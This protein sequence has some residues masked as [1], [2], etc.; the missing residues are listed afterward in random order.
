MS[1]TTPER[2]PATSSGGELPAAPDHPLTMPDALVRAARRFPAYGV[3]VVGPDGGR[4]LLSYPRLL[5]QAEAVLGGLRARGVEAGRYAVLRLSDA[6][7]F[8]VFWGCVLG[9]AVPVTTGGP[10]DYHAGDPAVETIVHCWRSLDRPVVVGGAADLDGLRRLPLAGDV[11]AAADLTAGVPAP[12]EPPRLDLAGESVAMLQLSSG[13]TG[14]PKIVPLTHR[15]ISEYAAGARA[16]LDIRAGDVLL[17]WLPLDHIA[18]LLLYHIGGVFLGASS[19]HVDTSYVLA[20]PLRWLD[21]MQ[22]HG[23]TH[24][25]APN[26]GYQLVADAAAAAPGRSWDLRTVRRLVSGGEQCLPE[27]FRA[28]LGATAASG[29]TASM[30]TMGWGMSETATGIAFDSFGRTGSLHRVRPASLA[31]QVEWA[32]AGEECVELLSVGPP[33]PGAAFRIVD[34]DNRVLPEGWVGRL[35]VRSA[36][37]TPGYVGDPEATQAAYPEPGWLDT[38]DLAFMVDGRV[39]ITGRAKDIIVLNGQN[40]LSHEIER[41]ADRTEGTLPGLVAACGVPDPGSGTET[42]VVFYAPDPA[43]SVD[44]DQVGR[45]IAAAVG[46]RLRLAVAATVAVPAADFPRTSGGKIQRAVLRERFLAGAGATAALERATAASAGAGGAPAGG[47]GPTTPAAVRRAVLDAAAAVAGRPVDPAT[48]FYELG[49]GS[50]Q[51]VQLRARLATALGREVPQPALFAHPSVDALADH[52]AGALEQPS[53]PAA[54]PTAEGRVAVIGMAARLPGAATVE[55]LWANL[56]AGVTS[57]HR[58]TTAELAAAGVPGTDLADPDFVPVS[59]VLD[60]IA[61][62]DAAFF[63][64]SPKEA[65]LLDP[66]H[67]L[68]LEVCHHAL[69]DAGYAGPDRSLRIGLFAG[70]GMNLYTHHTYLRHNLAAAVGSA[71][72]AT[73]LGAALGNLPDFLATRVAYRLGLTGPAVGVQT[74]CST[75]LVAVHLAI[76][77]LLAGDADIA[78]VGAAAVH[79]PQVTGYRYADGSILSRSGRCR[80]FDAEADGTVG[81]NGVAAV[82]LKTLDRA[83]ADGDTIHAVILGSAVNNDG[84]TKVGFTAPGVAGQVD[85]VRAALRAAG[86]PAGSVGYVE[87]HGTGTALG[88]PVEYQALA[89]AYQGGTGFLGSVKANVGHLDSCAG[90][91]GLL[92]AVLAV[93]TGQVPPQPGFDRPHPAIDL[94]GGPFRITTELVGWPEHAVPRRAGVSALGVGGTNAHVVVEEPPVAPPIST[95]SGDGVPALLPL[96]AADPAALRELAAAYRDELAAR[97]GLRPADL[98]ATTALGRRH[99]RHRLVALGG[100]AAELAAAL[101]RFVA[102]EAAGSVLTGQ[103]PAEGAGP[104]AFAFPGQG[105]APQALLDLAGRFGVVRDVL[106]QAATAY[107]EAAGADLPDRLRQAV[108]GGLSTDLAQPALVALGLGLAALWRSWGVRP[109]YVLGHSVGEYAALAAAGAL[110]V[111]DAV[112]LAAHRGRLMHDLLGPGA[113]LAVQADRSTVDELMTTV[114][115]LAL[116]AVNGPAQHVVAGPAGA[117]EEAARHAD[118]AGVRVRRL[119]VDRAFHTAAVEP[120]LDRFRPVVDAVGFQ[121]LQLPFVS[122]VDGSVREPGWLPDA[123]YLCRQARQPVELAAAVRRL[124]ADGCRVAVEAGPDRVLAGMAAAVA[125]TV[126]WVPSQHRG[127]RPVAGVWRAVAAA[128]CAGVPLDWAA[129]VDGCG[130]RR[131]QLPRYPFQRRRYWVDGQPG[132]TEPAGMTEPVEVT[133]PADVARSADV[134]EAQPPGDANG[135]GVLERVRAMTASRLGVPAS[136]VGPEDSFLG[137]G[138]DSFLLVTM[139]REVER[140]LGA[141]IPVRDLFGEVSTPRRLAEAITA[142]AGSGAPGPPAATPIE[143]ASPAA[144]MPAAAMPEGAVHA[145][146]AGSPAAARTGVPAGREL[147]PAPL[148]VGEIIRQQLDLMGRQLELLARDGATS[149]VPAAAPAFVPAAASTVPEQPAA[150]VE[151]EPA[152]DAADFSLYFFGDYPGEAGDAYQMILDA[153]EFG[154]RHG[155]HALWVPERHFHSFGGIFPN[156]SVLA[157]ALAVRTRRIR[158]NAGSVVLPLHHPVRVAEEWSVVDNLSGGRVGLGCAPGWHSN[159]FV[160]FPEH[161]G[162]H[163]QVMYEHLDTVRRLWRGEAVPARSGTGEEIEVRLFPRP[164]Q[165]IPPVFTAVVGNPDSY[166]EAARRDI[167]VVTNLMTQDVAQLA[168]NIA[169]YRRTRAEHGLDP[170]GGRVVVLLHTYLGADLAQARERAFEPFCGYLRSSFSLLGQVANSLGIN[171]DLDTTPDDDVRFLLSRAYQRYCEQRAL[172]GTV[173]SSRD[174]VRAV[175]DA[176]VDEVACF[177]D[178]GL[179]ADAVRDGLPFIDALRR[180][181]PRRP[182]TA[183]V[184]G[185]QPS[186]KPQ[187]SRAAKPQPSRAAEPQPFRAA[188]P[189]PS[190]AAGQPPPEIAPLSPAQRRLWLVEQMDPGSPAYN[191]AAAIRLAGP[192]DT[193]AL[194]GALTDVV[195]RHAPLRTTYRTMDGE[196]VQVVHERVPVRCPVVDHTG[197]DEADAVRQALAEESRRV[198]DLAEGPVFALR[199]LRF[200]ATHHVLV[201]AFHHLATDGRSY[202]VLTQDVSACYRAR[203]AGGTPAL[204]PLPVT[205][206]QLARDQQPD[207]ARLEADLRYWRERLHPAPP[208]LALPSDL[209]RPTAPSAAGRS[210]FETVPAEVAA[211]VRRF[212]RATR[213]TPFT[214]LLSAFAVALGRAGGQDDLVIGTGA[215]IRE[216]RCEDL[217]GFFVDTV[218]LRLSLAGDPAFGELAA[219]VQQAAADGYAHS[220]VAFDAL[221]REVAP[222][223]ESGRNP[224]F[225]VAIEYENGGAFHF[226]LPGVVATPLPYGLDK[227][228]VDLMV[229]V[230][231]GEEIRCHIEFRTEVLDEASVRRLF[232][233][234]R[235]VLER[236]T[237]EPALRLSRLAA[238]LDHPGLGVCGPQVPD[239]GELLHDLFLRQANRTPDAVAVV[240]GETRWSYRELRERA[241]AVAGR[242]A[243]A[244]AGP[245]DVVAVLLPR[246]PE[247]V[248]AQLGVLMAGAAFLPL[249][250][251]YP[252]ARL[253]GLVADSGARLVVTTAE[254]SRPASAVPDI[255]AVPDGV[256]RLL[257]EEAVAAGLPAPYARPGPGQAAWCVYT[258]GSTGA[259]KGVLVPHRAAVNAIH[260]HVSQLELSP[261]DSVC[262]GLALGFDANLS[263]IYPALA[264]GAS[265]H[266]VPDGARAEPAA[267]ADWWERQGITVAFLPAPLAELVF[268]LPARVDGALR[269]LVVGGSALRRRPPV[270][271]PARVLNAYGPTEN[272]IVTTAGPV[273][274]GDGGVVDIGRPTDNVRIY[275]LDRA[276]AAVPPGAAGELYVAGCGLAL[277]YLG[278]PGETAAAFLPEPFSGETGARMYR[279]GD[280]VRLRGDGT[281]EFLGRVDDQVKIAGHRVEP[282]EAGAALA[283]LPGV[284]QAVVTA[285]HDRG[286][287][288]YLVGYVVAGDTDRDP[289]AR[290]Q[291][292]LAAALAQ[293]V[294][295]HL[296]PRAWVF[297][298]ELPVGETGKVDL[299]ALPAPTVDTGGEGPATELERA[300]HDAWCAELGVARLPVDTAFLAAGGH[301]LA[302]VRLANRLGSLLGT[303]VPVHRVLRSPGIRALAATLAAG[304]AVAGQAVAGQAVADLALDDLALDDLAVADLDTADQAVQERAPATYQQEQMWGRA[305]HAGDPASVHIA[306][307]VELAG[308]LSVPALTEAFNTLVRRHAALR[309][310]LVERDGTLVQ[311]VLAHRPVHIPVCDLPPEGVDAWAV[312]TGREPFGEPPLLRAALAR[313]GEDLWVLLLVVHHL[314]ADGWSMLRIFEELGEAYAAALAGRAPALAPIEASYAGY[315]RRQRATPTDPAV[316]DYWRRQLAGAP[317]KLEVPTDRP[318]PPR[319]TRGAEVGFTVPA[320]VTGRLADLARE[321]GTTLFPVV[322]SAYALLLSRLIGRDDVAF[323]CPYA[324]RDHPSHE[325]VVGLFANAVQ[326]RLRPVAG[327]TFAELVTAANGVLLDAMRYRP[328]YVVEICREL[329]PGWRPGTAPPVGN[330]IFAWNPGMPQ[331][332]LPGLVSRVLDQPL[333]CAR[334]D[335]SVAVSQEGDALV[336]TVE[337]ATDL[338]DESTV[339]GWCDQLV[340]ILDAVATEPHRPLSSLAST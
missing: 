49:M 159:D 283:R 214:T 112:R 65:R 266:S 145:G 36:R 76:R 110:S 54:A 333:D 63:G 27:T 324:Y 235:R 50:I 136:Q 216:E 304:Q 202:A 314:A 161:Y 101:D 175:L 41:V 52:L 160:F 18:G 171:I 7:F 200:S 180:A 47:R 139:A 259:P 270:G 182:R 264:A 58:F 28:F 121:P 325:P 285:R 185:E 286:D 326:I 166:R 71:D 255:A 301:S 244:G 256:P 232:G 319:S 298:P 9:G 316:L 297:L 85:V 337:Y 220:G 89:E 299:A 14:T 238:E 35:H 307:R 243:A 174:V 24:G 134:G 178:F 44:P 154:D 131:V 193:A 30:L 322:L 305:R 279:T 78:L 95:S 113:M 106:G 267:L 97:P 3:H 75:S 250:P 147:E 195:A 39:T 327:S 26:F 187:P 224:L 88:D 64:I 302:A 278:R 123:D 318:R 335:L 228:P 252:A 90:M 67:R 148:A 79:V 236:A 33:A 179:P 46:R 6:E 91:A 86:V 152:V 167:G 81:G 82:V 212:S 40:Y 23:A 16:M 188:E 287:E 111:A 227:A 213:V 60:D 207:T 17:N 261:R 94:A 219:R 146:A 10:L 150:P 53:G 192:L 8:P 198:F 129:I 108:T 280:R 99:L 132:V 183:P 29:V 162:K 173:G 206:P 115:G 274:P 126:G 151:V 300:V 144:A 284:R 22:E 196:P 308:Q 165:A 208:G 226:D 263:E 294:P 340:R 158:I 84:A 149:A 15:A 100:G 48:P 92:K 230:S 1:S 116:A 239:P 57:L 118:K 273:A 329:D 117:V 317:R 282:A 163:K 215:S 125:A 68:F 105:S 254:E 211:R 142:A 194:Q 130:G 275:V 262:H 205:Y 184:V 241:Q 38:G 102:G 336:G 169:L 293:A 31:G 5:G 77:A 138:A 257:V 320:V 87:A 223:R 119:A 306:T 32:G 237:A 45:S 197:R 190:H 296:V 103:V 290:R 11:V 143:A 114:P 56:T 265:V 153:A 107:R 338:F 233:Y 289:P 272:A 313:T 109:D 201:M 156:P 225:D 203:V 303:D 133:E 13:S 246:R 72:P 332:S 328:A 93:R 83:L 157:A 4:E 191:E 310:R 69:E 242:V 271:F 321:L 209:P 309:T 258:S 251:A 168:G 323:A 42:L 249:D 96:S 248:A 104:V 21:L 268:A 247:L 334:R 170:A 37:N 51:I 176:G 312:A 217:V 210:L 155:F 292:R 295:Q 277:G 186:A 245:G 253:A 141:R 59:G 12:A 339:T 70:S 331:L 128:Y 43:S 260:W 291:A 315:A 164:V 199:L 98:V 25:W 61:G 73:S 135:A 20:D 140:E 124:A 240:A 122:T 34:S 172:I 66:Q 229:Y 222:A 127:H 204:P 74:A 330:M 177:V 120:V 2:P 221:V 276:G 181:T 288:P 137:L 62:F 311:E 55:E 80:P 189:Q 19:V 218:P 269:A 231:H 281:L 234:F